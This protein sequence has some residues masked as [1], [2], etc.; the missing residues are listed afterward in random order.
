M[1]FDASV[2]TG[3]F[4]EAEQWAPGVVVGSGGDGTLVTIKLDT[5]A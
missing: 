4:F 2:A 5:P 1:W 3:V